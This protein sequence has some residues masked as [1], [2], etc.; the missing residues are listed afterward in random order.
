MELAGLLLADCDNAV[1]R[2]QRS[3]AADGGGQRSEHAELS[4]IVAVVR[5]E[6]VPN[7]ASVA[8][9]RPE[10]AD[11][12]LE[13]HGRGRQQRDAERDARIADCE[14]RRE[15]VAS[16]DDEVVSAEQIFRGTRPNPLLSRIDIDEAVETANESRC[17]LSLGLAAIGFRKERL[18][19][20]VG[21]LHRVRIDDREPAHAGTGQRRDH[22]ASNAAGANY[23]DARRLELALAHAADLG[24]HDVPGIALKLFVGEVH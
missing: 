21:Q 15:I 14:P 19:M 13:L 22:R 11:L 20:Q 3:E 10:Q 2:Q 24:K 12:S 18:A 6:R 7:E 8:R 17:D 5:V 16:V 9:L 1:N 4:A 23:G